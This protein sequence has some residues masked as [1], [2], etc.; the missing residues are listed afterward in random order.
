MNISVEKLLQKMEEK[1]NEAK[2]SGSD[3]VIRERV[4]AIKT[5]CEL[6]LDEPATS[7]KGSTTSQ[8]TGT[9]PTYASVTGATSNQPARLII[10]EE[11]NGE[12]IFDF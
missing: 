5:M 7:S 2:Q 10:D 8:S 12:S 9:T 6:I 11:S 4:H 1:L 3:V